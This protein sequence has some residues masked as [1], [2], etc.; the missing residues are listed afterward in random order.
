MYRLAPLLLIGYTAFA[1]SPSPPT[2]EAAS[3]KPAAPIGPR[4]MFGMRGGRESRD[5]VQFTASFS[6]HRML[7]GRAYNVGSIEFL[8]PT[9]T[10]ANAATPGEG[11]QPLHSHAATR[12][13][14]RFQESSG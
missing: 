14:T 1:Q 5:A 7:L 3:V 4:V 13:E 11:P 12:P 9:G 8:A 2:C 6:T 10:R